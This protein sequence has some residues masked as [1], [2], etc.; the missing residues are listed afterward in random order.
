[1]ER[2]KAEALI[3]EIIELVQSKQHAVS[4]KVL[5]TELQ[6]SATRFQIQEAL[7]LG[8]HEGTLKL[9]DGFTVGVD[10]STSAAA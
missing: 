7:Q 9:G 10:S 3:Q 8:I 6:D 1:M 4:P 5:F 2:H